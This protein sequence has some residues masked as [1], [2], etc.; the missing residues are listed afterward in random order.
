ML[1][2]RLA[3]ITGGAR[4]IG[5]AIAHALAS[6]GARVIIVD[7]NAEAAHL[8]SEA[9]IQNGHQATARV[10][11]L[12][13]RDD[14]EQL[15][16]AVTA[17]DGEISILVNNAGIASG[18][19]I[20]D[21]DLPALWDRQLELNLTAVMLMTRAFVDSLRSTQGCVVNLASLSAFQAVTGSFGY[22]ASKGGVRLLTQVLARELGPD[23]IR[24]N[25][26]APGAIRTELTATRFA[27]EEW[28][29]AF[30]A[31]LPLGRLGEAEDVADP[32]VFLCSDAARYITGVTLPVDG[33]FLAV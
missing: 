24:V 3:L 16:S 12:L 4:G 8:Q 30:R 28:M 18:L 7:K 13:V 15:A 31:R 33:G 19:P 10:A 26:V 17:D 27:N 9:L 6:A 22:Q 21:P 14:I 1:E 32:V 29:Q 11:D 25:G 20:D 23:G 2:N 5:A